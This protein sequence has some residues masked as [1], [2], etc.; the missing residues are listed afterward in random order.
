[1]E[2]AVL[3]RELRNAGLI[4]YSQQF[5]KKKKKKNV[6]PDSDVRWKIFRNIF[7]ENC[8]FLKIIT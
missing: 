4:N 7:P 5:K 8:P 1:M 2:R 3:G 6:V